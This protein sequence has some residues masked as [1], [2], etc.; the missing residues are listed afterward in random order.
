MSDS[1]SSDDDEYQQNLKLQRKV[2]RQGSDIFNLPDCKYVNKSLC[3]E[4]ASIVKIGK[5]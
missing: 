1:E 4:L 5:S 2:M 3:Y